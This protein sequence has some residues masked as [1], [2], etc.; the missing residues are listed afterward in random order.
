[1][2]GRARLMR[3]ERAYL[4]TIYRVSGPSAVVDLR[5]GVRNPRLDRLLHRLGLRDWVFVTAW[6]PRSQVQPGW[7][8]R[9][10]QVRLALALRGICALPGVGLP[11]DPRWQPEASLFAAPV[12]AARARRLG[13][14]FGQNAVVAGRRGRAPAL[15]WM[16]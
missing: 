9:V 7:R 2:T 6:N 12:S 11:S 16:D 10:R 4:D 14:R 8:N 1:M 13:R 5:I 15:I 3:F